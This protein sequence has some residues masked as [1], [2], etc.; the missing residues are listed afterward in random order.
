MLTESVGKLKVFLCILGGIILLHIVILSCVVKSSGAPET[1][2]PKEKNN[3]GEKTEKKTAAS[4]KAEK[5][6]LFSWFG[7]SKKTTAPAPEVQSPSPPPKPVYKYRKLSED[8]GF[9][10][11]LDYSKAR[12]GTMPAHLIPGD[13]STA[14][15]LVDMKT[16]KV[17][18]EKNSHQMVPIASMSKMM[19]ILLTMEHVEKSPQLSLSTVIPI[20]KDVLHLP[21]REGIVWLDP[22]E[23]FPLSDLIKC[24]AIKSAN[25]AALQLALL[26]SGSE[27]DFVARMNEKARF[28]GMADTRFVN[29]HG[30]PTKTALFILGS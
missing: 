19:T 13:R 10:R 16:R 12:R 1:E 26:V 6:G 21:S 27:A 24:T 20:S 29:A 30:L 28:L 8:P 18:W 7:G 15:I 14:A 17:L 23:R 4:P 22:R 11:A 2:P 25:D 3:A 9:G 5:K